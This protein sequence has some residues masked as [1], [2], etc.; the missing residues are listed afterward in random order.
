MYRVAPAAVVHPRSEGDLA[1][2]MRT[3]TDSGVPLTFRGGGSGT[4][5]AA[6]GS[7]ILV[8]LEAL[9]SARDIRDTDDSRLFRAGAAVRHGTFQRH[10]REHGYHSGA[11]ALRTG[12]IDRYVHSMRIML[13]DGTVIDTANPQTVPRELAA[14]VDK[15]RRAVATEPALHELRTRLTAR[16][17][18]KYAS[19][20][21][22]AALM[23]DAATAATA[24]TGDVL[25]QLMCG[26]VG[27]LAAVLDVTLRAVEAET[28][29]ITLL[30]PAKD[31]GAACDFALECVDLG[32]T[33][34]ELMDAEAT[35]FIRDAGAGEGPATRTDH[36]YLYVELRGAGGQDRREAVLR[37]AGAAPGVISS[38]IHA[39][40]TAEE[41]EELWKLR[42]RL[43]LLIRRT[44]APYR[45]LS[46]VNDVGVPA[47]SLSRFISEAAEIFSSEGL[48]API[49]GHAGS[50]NLHLRPLF[51]TGRS[52]LRDQLRRVADRI[53]NR[54]IELNGTITAEHGMGRLRAPYLEAEWGSAAVH[55]F[56]RIKSL[57]DPQDVLSGEAMFFRGDITE[58]LDI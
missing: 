39:A 47:E 15:L 35:A 38:E 32:A 41:Q 9:E 8:S 44:P 28:E 23:A 14:G 45:A 10:L 58:H 42:K 5:G 11:H 43:L 33:A 13:T 19:G 26:S 52:D 20:Y 18:W 4:G 40:E 57:F 48:R 54:V 21:N 24:G 6:L 27:T 1:E 49:Y 25:A 36:D 2:L 29:A 34:V 3:A 22:V 46:V 16:R 17:G 51:D 55:L 12:A 30:V 50:G 37:A 31:R 7:A 53:Y 56:R